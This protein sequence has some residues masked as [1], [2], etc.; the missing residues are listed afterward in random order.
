MASPP[1][2]SRRPERRPGDNLHASG[3]VQFLPSGPDQAEDTVQALL[4][5]ACYRSERRILAVTPYFVPDAS[6]S[7]AL[8]LAA[9]RGVAIDLC[10]PATSNHILAD[11][12]RS[13]A[14]RALGETGA[15]IHLLPTMV[16]AKGIVID[17]MLAVC[18]SP[19][20]DS[21][22]L[23]LNYESAFVLYGTHEISWLAAWIGALDRGIRARSTT[24]GP[25]CGAMSPRVCC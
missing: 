11:F 21:R 1:P 13:R 2:R 25:R 23:L 18:G 3:R 6:L 4:L 12:A 7:L 14:L 15:A 8:R 24:G 19:N 10:L 5:D 22:S 20:L 17:E 9:R 16:H